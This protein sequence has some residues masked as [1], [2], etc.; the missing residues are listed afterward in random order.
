MKPWLK[1]ALL[2]CLPTL[3]QGQTL[4][5]S[6]RVIGTG[7]SRAEVAGLCGEPADVQHKTLYNNVTAGAPGSQNVAAGTTVEVQLE[8]WTYNFGPDKLMQRIQFED[9]IIVHIE[10]VGY[11]Y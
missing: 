2:A 4:Q 7:M 9:G 1:L 8:V 3:A 5:C 11:G 10:S 6:D